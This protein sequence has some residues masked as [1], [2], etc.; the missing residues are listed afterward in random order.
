[1]QKINL[2]RIATFD[3]ESNHWIDFEVLGFFDGAGY[4]T[5]ARIDSFLQ[6]LENKIY[7][8]FSI[9]AHN[10]GKFDFLFLMEPMMRRGW[11]MSISERN[12]RVMVIEVDTG[13]SRFSFFDSYSILPSSLASLCVAFGVEHQKEKFDFRRQRVRRNDPKIL[14]RLENDCKGLFEILQSFYSSEYIHNPQVTIAS[15]AL[16]TFKNIFLKS[17]VLTLPAEHEDI[18][19]ECFYAGGRVEVFKGWGRGVRSYD[20][21]SLFPFAMLEPMPVGECSRVRSYKKGLIGFY[22]VDIASTPDW[23]ISPLLV[24]GEKNMFVK[25]R[26]RYY[27]SSAMIEFLLKEYGVRC[28]VNWGFT[29]RGGET[30][31]ADYVNTFY[32]MKSENRGNAMYYIAKL[33][34]NSLYGKFAQNR[35]KFRIEKFDGQTNFIA[36]EGEIAQKLHLVLVPHRSQSRFILPYLSAWIT[37]LARLYHFKLMREH[38]QDM[39]YCDTDSLFTSARYPTGDNIGELSYKGTFQGCFLNSKTYALKST[40]GEEV[41]F[42]GFNAE[43][44]RFADFM[45]VMKKKTASLSQRTERILTYRQ[46]LTRVNGITHERGAFLK[47]VQQ[48]KESSC[49]YDKRQMIRSKKFIFDTR[50][51]DFHD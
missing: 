11:T 34:L 31:L 41:K 28:K 9:F 19:R 10:G 32:K 20:V 26:G 3:I 17:D 14:K 18:F 15:Q 30:I 51:F 12:G 40:D 43:E 37:D 39:F 35:E 23:Y 36:M 47:L 5:Y 21:N 7:N 48:E 1:M 45:N 49:D 50:P 4:W 46:C 13:K 6:R 16:D 24:K 38:E 27:V 29:F 22:C 33:F 2:D 8:G 25:G 42:K 44:F